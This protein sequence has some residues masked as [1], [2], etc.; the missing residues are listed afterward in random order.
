M[1]S[2]VCKTLNSMEVGAVQGLLLLSRQNSQIK[3]PRAQ[4]GRPSGGLR[5]KSDTF[6]APAVHAGANMVNIQ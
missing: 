6:D 2:R 4:I 3:S 1:P 5:A